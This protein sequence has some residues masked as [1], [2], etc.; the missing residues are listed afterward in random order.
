M[1]APFD[2]NAFLERKA[3][4]KWP[5]FLQAA[6]AKIAAGQGQEIVPV[7]DYE[8]YPMTYETFLSWYNQSDLSRVWD[9]YNPD[10]NFP[11]LK[12]INIPVLAILGEKDEQTTYP[13]LNV[14]P[15]SALNTIKKHIKNCQIVLVPACNHCFVGHEEIVAREVAGFLK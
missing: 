11:V 10:Y 7:P 12:K 3:P 15:K 9:F 5:E 1:L 6:E 14:S 13:E 8:D 2:K 4:C